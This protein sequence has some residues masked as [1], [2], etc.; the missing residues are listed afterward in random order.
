MPL[1]GEYWLVLRDNKC[2]VD[3]VKVVDSP[4]GGYYLVESFGIQWFMPTGRFIDKW[5]PNWFWRLLGYE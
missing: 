5:E 3:I 2:D 4:Y 1:P